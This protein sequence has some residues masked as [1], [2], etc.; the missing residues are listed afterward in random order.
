MPLR[1]RILEEGMPGDILFVQGD[2]GATCAMARWASSRGLV[3]VY[4][5][6]KRRAIEKVEGDRVTTTRVFEHVRFR[7]YETIE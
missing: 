4:A 7:V 5:T 6:T 3:P 2:F 1:T